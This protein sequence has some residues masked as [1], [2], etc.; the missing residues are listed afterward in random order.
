MGV[1][2][3][4]AGLR[5]VV[6]EQLATTIIERAAPGSRAVLARRIHE[7]IAA[8]KTG[9]RALLRAAAMEVSLA[10]AEWCVLLDAAD[11]AKLPM[12]VN[13]R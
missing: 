12:S 11:N 2:D 4:L 10:A 9:D 6:A 8:E 1:D 3:E 13:G 7:L 5:E